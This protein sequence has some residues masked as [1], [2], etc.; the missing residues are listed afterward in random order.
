MKKHLKWIIPLCAVLL[1]AA[2]GLGVFFFL[3]SEDEAVAPS[4]VKLYWNVNGYEYHGK[5]G[6]VPVRQPDDNGNYFVQFAGY[7]EQVRLQV[8]REILDKGLDVHEIVGLVIDENGIVTDFYPVEDCTGGYFCEKYY[9]ESIEGNTVTCNSGAMYNGFSISFELTEDV[10]VYRAEGN[11][12]LTG[13]PTTIQVDDEITAI[14]DKNGKV[15]MAFV[16]PLQEIPD[17]YWNVT[18]M[19]NSTTQMTTREAD[20]LGYYTYEMALNGELTTVR[21]R[22]MS[23]A[24]A[25]DKIAARN[26]FL[27][28]DED[29][30]VSSVTDGSKATGGWVASWCDTTLLDGRTMEFTRTIGGSNQG[31]VYRCTAANNFVA[32]D[33]SGG[34]GP[35]GAKTELRLGDRVHCLTNKRGQVCISFVV[36]RIVDSEMY[37]NVERRYDSTEKTTTRHVKADGY[38]HVLVAVNGEQKWV[39]VK[40]RK[41]VNTMDARA[42]KHFG[43]KLNGDIVEKVYAPS[44][45]T[46]GTYFA[47][48]CD[49]TKIEDGTV[50][51][52]RT[53]ESS[54]YGSVYT[55]K[56]APDCKVYNVTG[57]ATVVGEVTDLRVGDRIHGE[58]NFEGELVVIYVVDH[59]TV[60]GAKVYWNVNRMYNSTT[61]QSTRQPDAD[62]W[63]TFLLACEGEQVTVKTK[64]ASIVQKM[65]AKAD[66]YF[67]LK[68]NDQ[69]EITR[70]MNASSVTGGSYFASWCDVIEIDGDY[71]TA[72]RTIGGSNQGTKYTAKMQKDVKVYNVS[73]NYINFEGEE[74]ELRVGDRIQGQCNIYGG[75]A[76]IF[77]VHRPD[78]PGEPD[79]FHCACNGNSVGIGDHVCDSETGW[80]AWSNPR[81]LPTSGSWYL[82]TDVQLEA[83]VTVP[84]GSTLNLCL[85]GHTVT[86]YKGTSNAFGVNTG[87]TITDCSPEEQWGSIIGQNDAY[88][89]VMYIYE[90]KAPATV[91]LFAGHLKS[92]LTTPKTKD[93]GLIYIGSNGANLAVFNM[94]GGTL[95]GIDAGEKVGGAINLI[96]GNTVNLYGGTIYGGEAKYGGAIYV[97]KGT[98]NIDGGTIEGGTAYS[99]GAIYI[100]NGTLNVHSGA[101]QNGYA[102]FDGGNVFADTGVINVYG[103][104]ISGGAAA[105]EGGNLRNYGTCPINLY[106]GT[107]KDG[108]KKDGVTVTK[109]GGNIM[110]FSTLTIDGGSVLNGKAKNAGGNISTW[111]SS[112]KVILK[113]GSVENGGASSGSNI[114]ISNSTSS[115]K[116]KLE[117][118]GGLVAKGGNVQLDHGEATMTGGTVADGFTISGQSTLHISGAA[119]IAG[120]WDFNLQL[121]NNN[122]VTVGDLT[123]GAKICVTLANSGGAFAQLTDPADKAYFYSDNTA[124]EVQMDSENKLYIVG[125]HSHCVCGGHYDDHSC[126]SVNWTEWTDTTSLPTTSGNYYLSADVVLPGSVTIPQG[127]D[128]K[129]CLNGHKISKTGGG[130]VFY[131][132]GSFSI[133]DCSAEDKWGSVVGNTDTYGTIMYLYEHLASS[134]VNIY[135]GNYSSTL[136]TQSKD[137][138][139][140]YIGNQGKNKAT[141]NLYNGKLTGVDVGKANGG[142]VNIIKGNCMN[143]YG[144]TVTGGKAVQGGGIRLTDGSTFNMYGGIIENNTATATSNSKGG[145]VYAANT[146]VVTLRGGTIRNNR[147]EFDG[148]GVY[149]MD[150]AKLNIYEGAKITLNT[151]RN[152][153]GNV[154]ENPKTTINMY[155]GE[156]SSGS[157]GSGGNIMM[158]GS[159]NMYSGTIKDGT[160]SNMGGNINTW[161]SPKI[162]LVKLD[163][164][165]T[166]PVISGGTAKS[167]NSIYLRGTA[168]TLKVTFGSITGST[169]YATKGT[170]TVGGT[171]VIDTLHLNGSALA[172]EEFTGEASIGIKMTTPGTF[173][174]GCGDLTAYF[175]SVD[176]AYEATFDGTNMTLKKK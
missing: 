127:G 88:G 159:L 94:Y 154:R 41:L 115:A 55:A 142:V 110:N 92:N 136:T 25:M 13:M 86:G 111:G 48:W 160:A 117:I 93:A 3:G 38:Y 73:D 24:N 14:Q 20:A 108:G 2:A 6:E 26:M 8:T 72:Q 170:V 7:G 137:G 157:A 133:T 80:S 98:L 109:K 172:A 164:Y 42:D 149:L 47:S 71:V 45:C 116:S 81:R 51:A 77:V 135:A 19:Y 87:L 78:I 31:T 49:V 125:K 79:H 67:G 161:S 165:D 119:V 118:S 63:Y 104:T 68:V 30:L 1:L 10:Q 134:T 132:N 101:I 5:P 112:S 102:T 82:T 126:G 21:T 143:M 175:T 16:S 153:G 27:T 15:F 128:V 151:A 99:G 89:S 147:S 39:R 85:N 138:G 174:T 32:Y 171:A 144:G 56:M 162:N 106:G 76:I 62:G 4:D 129:L 139:L 69:G 100:K 50:T 150:S 103:G 146:A 52:V 121:K 97:G 35:Y 28:F 61:K 34:D 124:F 59:R 60:P 156:I 65:D 167:G 37:W 46:G 176:S 163:G 122:M 58:T 17:I 166:A 9:V 155:G 148:G 57:A 169:V 74:T 123:E 114:F 70:Y 91:N 105:N 113:S 145:G 83:T 84:V 64:D 29:G 158:F 90:N 36:N 43:L 130:S 12:P 120:R 54:N 131:V 53:I 75:L 152:E 33:V 22:N 18:R 44:Q 95:T 173:L 11:S 96:H 168:P 23:V 140:F 141:L 107:V 40:D 66:C